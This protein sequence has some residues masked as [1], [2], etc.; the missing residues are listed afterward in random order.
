MFKNQVQK[1]YQFVKYDKL[2]LYKVYICLTF[3]TIKLCTIQELS[4]W[5][6]MS[7]KILLQM[8]IYPN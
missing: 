2:T 3:R 1:E 5:A 4:A 6:I 7:Q 8:M